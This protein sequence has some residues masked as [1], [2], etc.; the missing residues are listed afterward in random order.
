MNS[1]PIPQILWQPSKKFAQ[2]SRLQAFIKWLKDKHQLSFSNYDELWEW[3]V[4]NTK[5]FWAAVWEYFAIISHSSYTEI[6]TDDPMPDTR[7]FPGATLNYAEHIFRNKTSLHPA[8]IYQTETQSLSEISWETLEDKVARLR[9]YLKKQGVKKGDRIAAYFP[10]TPEATIAFLAVC[11][12]GVVWSSCSPDFGTN[13]ILDRFSQIEPKVLFVVDGYHYGGKPFNKMEVVEELCDKMPS[14]EKVIMVPFL[15]SEETGAH[16]SK[17]TL[18]DKVME[19]AAE[20]LAFEPVPFDHP[21]W[22]L[23]SSGTTGIPKAITHSH[24][25]NLLEH[26]KYLAFH[27]D[28]HPGERFF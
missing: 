21:I 27:N 18:W 25:G 23:Y 22:V 14:V 12:L 1:S 6:H 10:N 16:I 17:L 19:T 2:N 20:P 13:S 8:I 3:S 7:W 26:F 15:N 28:V 24:G 5:D 11:S 4:E 9:T